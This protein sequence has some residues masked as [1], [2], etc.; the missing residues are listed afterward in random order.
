MSFLQIPH[1][2]AARRLFLG[3]SGLALSSVAVALLAGKDAWRHSLA[4]VRS[5]M[6]RSSTPRWEQNS[7]PSL[8]IS[9]ARKAGCCKSPSWIWR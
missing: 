5:R 1:R 4:A 8:P 3:Q 9:W 2:A 6:Y 7:R